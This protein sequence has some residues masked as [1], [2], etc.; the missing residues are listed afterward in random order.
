MTVVLAALFVGVG[1]AVIAYGIVEHLRARKETLAQLLEVE[2]AEP[3]TPPD[4]LAD[5][6]ERAG[7]FA[8]RA[9]SGTSTVRRIQVLLGQ[10]GWSLRAGEF[11]AVLAV[12]TV[13][14]A[15]LATMVA[16]FAAG[17]VVA[18]A[19]PLSVIA[20]VNRT[21]RKR[22]RA[23]ED[24]LP[25]VLQLLA[26]SLDSGTSLLHALEM[27][28]EEGRPP[29]AEE[30]ARVIGETRVGRPL[31]ESLEA[32][33][34]RTGSR[35]VDWTVEAMR[36]QMQTGGK[37]ADTLRV[38]ADFMRARVEVRGE[39]QA[40]SAEA[41]LSAKILT[42][43]PLLLSGYML[44]FRRDYFQPLYSTSAGR[45]MLLVAVSGIVL[46]TVW[47]RRIVRVEV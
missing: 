21:G 17:L 6:M 43:L 47:M 16:S 23:I 27:V 41:R 22:V 13:L 37:L 8:D 12:G 32:M 24:Q 30:F 3:S 15:A 4:V 40:L 38:L 35:D 34:Q 33:A 31:M 25:S 45:T 44:A 46:G 5:M 18:V 36:I 29:L 20:W 11:A 10:A 19:A 9:L 28:V 14:L 39:V 7:A 42:G 2:L 1:L 26:G